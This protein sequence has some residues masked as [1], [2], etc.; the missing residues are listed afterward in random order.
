MQQMYESNPENAARSEVSSTGPGAQASTGVEVCGFDPARQLP[1]SAEFRIVITHNRV[2]Q[3]A[4]LNMGGQRTVT[5]TWERRRGSRPGWVL[6]G[7]DS[8]FIAAEGEISAELATFADSV[9]FPFSVANMLPGTRATAEAVA[10]A[11]Q[12]VAHA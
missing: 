3:I 6:V 5:R 10:A 11:A 7:H 4:T 9:D 12:E 8:E 2:T 1:C